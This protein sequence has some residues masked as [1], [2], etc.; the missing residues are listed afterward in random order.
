MGYSIPVLAYSEYRSRC[1]VVGGEA[2]RLAKIGSLMFPKA[3]VGGVH[4]ASAWRGS[5]RLMYRD[6]LCRAP[7]VPL[8]CRI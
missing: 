8:G 6:R 5:H 7:D 3:G 2:R 1:C 4:H